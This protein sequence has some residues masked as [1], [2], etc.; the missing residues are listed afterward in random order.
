MQPSQFQN[1]REINSVNLYQGLDQSTK[2]NFMFE[3]Q[4]T[5]QLTDPC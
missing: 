4:E 2:G 1:I 5:V 3:G